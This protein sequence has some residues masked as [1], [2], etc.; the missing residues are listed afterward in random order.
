MITRMKEDHPQIT[1]IEKDHPQITQIA[2]RLEITLASPS[3]KQLVR[4]CHD[5]AKRHSHS[6]K[7]I[8]ISMPLMWASCARVH[9]HPGS[10][11]HAVY[12]GVR[13]RSLAS[14]STIPDRRNRRNLRI[15]SP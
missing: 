2:W 1:R 12:T 4:G 10:V 8:G 5:V 3:Q 7:A 11:P 15:P 9:E 6:L 13:L 14:V